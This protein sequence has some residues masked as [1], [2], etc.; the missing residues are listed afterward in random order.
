MEPIAENKKLMSLVDQELK[1]L[2]NAA[3]FYLMQVKGIKFPSIP[4]FNINEATVVLLKETLTNLE[5][6]RTHRS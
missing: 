1:I 4:G 3:C 6:E 2:V 5:A